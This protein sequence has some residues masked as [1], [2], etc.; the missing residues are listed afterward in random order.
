MTGLRRWTASCV[1]M[2]MLALPA[3]GMAAET[4]SAAPPMPAPAPAAPTLQESFSAASAAAEA[5]D[6]KTAMPVFESLASDPRIK[7]GSLPA[8]AIAVRRGRCLL[9]AGDEEKGTALMLSG[10][11]KLAASGESFDNEV[12]AAHMLLGQLAL[13]RFDHDEAVRQ[14]TSA[15]AAADQTTRIGALMR[16]A[17]T[18]QFDGDEA[19]LKSIGKAL[20]ELGD[21]TKQERETMASLLTVRGRALMNLGRNK[22]AAEDLKRALP[23]SGG[24]TLK[25][26]L[27]DVS[28][29]GDLAQAMLLLG[30]RNEA[31]KY[32]AYTGAGRIENSPFAS[33]KNMDVPACTGEAGLRPEDSAVVEFSINADGLVSAA[34][35]VYSRGTYEAASTFA[36]AVR[37]WTWRPDSLVKMPAFY[38]NLVRVELHCTTAD[39]GAR[40]Q[41]T[42]AFERL[43]QWAAPLATKDTGTMFATA[44]T[45]GTEGKAPRSVARNQVV[46]KLRTVAAQHEAAGRTMAAGAAHALASIYDLTESGRAEADRVQAMRLI[47]AADP[48]QRDPAVVAALATLRLYQ[49]NAAA[50]ASAGSKGDRSRESWAKAYEVV[51]RSGLDDPLINADALALDTLKV[52]IATTPRGGGTGADEVALLQAVA[53]DGRL[54]DGHPLR[55][56]ALL[57]LATAAAQAKRIDVA[58]AFFTRTGL[59]SQQCSLIGDIPRLKADNASGADYPQE[60]LL[61]GFEGWVKMEYDIDSAGRT[62]NQR[63]LIAYPPF[64]FVE[65]AQGIAR[66]VRYDPSYRPPGGLACSATSETVRFIIP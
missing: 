19:A 33:A 55:Q 61:M 34:Q 59:T 54:P 64:V 49:L 38:R 16:L 42:P 45:G 56:L 20:A 44:E 23:L 8:A 47:S 9:Q 63:A 1:V 25:V 30:Q 13:L 22:E 35:T 14:F 21:K 46:A 53:D 2:A 62:A 50:R 37:D 27:S 41:M 18:T 48:Q 7:P 40:D 65:A 31:R 12:A 10:L 57:R 24:L 39:A 26:S 58:Q 51:V 52:L 60:A 17:Q 3:C 32:L 43:S 66:G 29:R 15:S 11:P 4:V 6:C 28:L 5:G 36:Q